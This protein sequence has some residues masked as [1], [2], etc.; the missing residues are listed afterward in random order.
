MSRPGTGQPSGPARPS[1]EE[2]R[3]LEPA[4]DRLLDAAPGARAALLDDL[5]DGDARQRAELEQ[6]VT[7]CERA[8]PLL[9]APAGDRFPAVFG[10][11]APSMPETLAGRYRVVREAGRGGMAIVYLARDLKHG[12]D[13]A[14][15]VVRP[16]LALALGR[17][18]FLR[19]IEIAA[20]LRHPHIVP[21]YDSGEEPADP[22]GA[23]PGG[24]GA[25][26]LYYVIPY[27]PGRSLRVRL[28]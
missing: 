27:E 18:R 15:K 17:S 7:E 25:P 13:V 28:L 3:R 24:A 19:E 23:G 21:V 26:L 1:A 22:P 5:S 20:R 16:E 10:D 9:E 11:D 8:Y 4:L 12:R 6:L 2:W 14:V